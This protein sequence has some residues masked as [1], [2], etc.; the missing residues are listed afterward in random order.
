MPTYFSYFNQ[1]EYNFG[2]SIVKDITNLPKYTAIFSKIADDVSFYSYYT[3]QPGRRLDEISEELYGTPEFYWT[4]FLVNSRII[5]VWKDL[6]KSVS[7]TKQLLQKKY[8]G[9][10]FPIRD[11]QSIAGK[12]EIGESLVFNTTNKATLTG[13]YPTRG[14]LTG[15]VAD[16]SSFPINT[17]MTLTG[18]DSGDTVIVNNRIPA[19]EAPAYHLDSDGNRVPFNAGQVTPV[20]LRQVEFDENDVESQIKVIRPEFIFDV[21]SRFENEMRT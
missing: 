4:I 15:E 11:D 7:A 21:S 18:E 17:E 10:A 1:R 5:N 6:P 8:P 2:D 14:Y 16:G 3:M 9:V 13:V 20:S 19:S 12:F